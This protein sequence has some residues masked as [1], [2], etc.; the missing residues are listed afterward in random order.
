M[1]GGIAVKNFFSN[2]LVNPTG[3]AVASLL[4]LGPSALAQ[5][6]DPTRQ[7]R[8]LE[9]PQPRSS[10]RSAEVVIPAAPVDLPPGAIDVMVTPRA[11]QVDGITALGTAFVDSLVTP[12]AGRTTSV[13]EL[14]ELAASLTRA[15]RERGYVLS[16]VIVP[17]QRITD[18]SV[19]RLQAIEGY[20]AAVQWPD[21]GPPVPA[22][23]RSYLA[24]VTESRPLRVQTLERALLLANDV[25]GYRVRAVLAPTDDTPGA[26][27]LV[28]TLDRATWSAS[29]DVDDSGTTPVG[30]YRASLYAAY[31]GLTNRGEQTGLSYTLASDPKELQQ[32]SITH[33]ELVGPY[34][35]QVQFNAQW[36]EVRPGGDLS[37]FDIRGELWMQE[38]SVRHPLI[39]SRNQNL[40]ARAGV[41]N[42]ENRSSILG[43]DQIRDDLRYV[44]VNL[45]YDFADAFRGVT[46]VSTE[47]RQGLDVFDARANSRVGADPDFTLL[48]LYAARNQALFD[49]FSIY[50]AV[51][52]QYAF[53]D[54][55]SSEETAFG[56]PVV[57]RG[58]DRSE[59]TGDYGVG[60]KLELRYALPPPP[61]LLRGLEVY[62][63]WDFAAAW[64]DSKGQFLGSAGRR[65]SL[66]SVGAGA[67]FRLP[68]WVGGYIELAQPLTKG[69]A[70]EGGDRDLRL[71]FALRLDL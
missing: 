31:N 49:R 27:V 5:A 22:V 42:L 52:G 8:D 6:L 54:T 18:G 61:R 3:A 28:L 34:G 59:V 71:N 41:G 9:E 35:T 66:A 65:Q 10:P 23:L 24:A 55:P 43:F 12:H 46:L 13:R 68:K 50:A 1:E 53:N 56:G 40:T 32:A 2:R 36:S 67:R 11:V 63:F 25:P 60:T 47:L 15:Y 64:E 51:F 16:E 14:Y 48:K 70:S 21:D 39:R 17:P 45:N 19:V 29:G 7:I 38:L 58:Y 20:I 33:S 4:L 69:I 30:E 62:G 44:F 57:G 26:A 37:I